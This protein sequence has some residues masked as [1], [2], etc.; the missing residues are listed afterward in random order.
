MPS[1]LIKIGNGDK[2]DLFT[3]E[4]MEHGQ[5]EPYVT[6]SYHWTL[7][8]SQPPRIA[9][10]RWNQTNSLPKC[11]QDALNITRAAGLRYLWISSLCS[12]EGEV[13]RDVYV[14]A[15]F[16]IAAINVRTSEDALV[17]LRRNQ[18]L[19]PIIKPAWTGFPRDRSIIIHDPYAFTNTVHSSPLFDNPQFHQQLFLSPATLFCT[20]NQMWWQCCDGKVYNEGFPEGD[21]F[22]NGTAFA[23][24]SEIEPK[25]VMLL[26]RPH[27]EYP[28][29]YEKSERRVAMW[30]AFITNYTKSIMPASGDRLSPIAEAALFL[31][32]GIIGSD[33][34]GNSA[35]YHSGMWSEHFIEQLTWRPALAALKRANIR[36]YKAGYPIPTWS[37]AS[38]DG[39][40]TYSFPRLD[41]SPCYS[42][43]LWPSPRPQPIAEVISAELDG[44]DTAGRASN[45]SQ[46]AL[47]LRGILIKIEPNKSTH[48]RS[49]PTT[50]RPHFSPTTTSHVQPITAD[51]IRI[52]T[53]ILFD[54]LEEVELAQGAPSGEY[55][56]LPLFAHC[57]KKSPCT[58]M[59]GLVLRPS[60]TRRG[61][62]TRAGTF[63]Y[64]HPGKRLDLELLGLTGGVNGRTILLV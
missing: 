11:F 50:P 39:P 53:S 33:L 16:N 36:R 57:F 17:S 41:S 26:D 31:R 38:I 46:C 2:R 10:G 54:C 49:L 44:I 29:G 18:D 40:V 1:K 51:D 42:P 35:V 6:L 24:P 58:C 12:E 61:A 59:M 47:C 30:T 43:I 14:G 60:L 7:P 23:T 63:K 62:Y 64:E 27:P 48:N 25:S 13:I 5:A 19:V 34:G 56:A 9:A 32:E 28:S 22:T 4:T 52:G 8:E 45:E 15:Q 55:M 37:W 3:I 21:G 20:E